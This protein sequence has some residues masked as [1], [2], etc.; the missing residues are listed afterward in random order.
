MIRIV[1]CIAVSRLRRRASRVRKGGIVIWLTQ[2]LVACTG[3]TDLSE[4]YVVI[5]P[6]VAAMDAWVAGGVLVVKH[7]AGR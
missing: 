2:V 3:L 1:L 5:T 6:D 4:D 7:H